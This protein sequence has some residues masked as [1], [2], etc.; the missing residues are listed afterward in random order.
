MS[1]LLMRLV[2]GIALSALTACVAASSIAP[3]QLAAKQISEDAP[4]A[5][6]N[7]LLISGR[8]EARPTDLGRSGTGQSVSRMP[9]SQFTSADGG[10]MALKQ[11]VAQAVP[12]PFRQAKVNGG[13]SASPPPSKVKEV[14][15]ND[16]WLGFLGNFLGAAVGAFVAILLWYWERTECNAPLRSTRQWI[17][18]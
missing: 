13:K 3:E 6:G 5:A 15:S 8:L 10:T 9:L 17:L 2:P 14:F 11:S 1:I 18:K 7:P 4:T 12:V 16:A